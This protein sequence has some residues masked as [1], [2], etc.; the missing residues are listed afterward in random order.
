MNNMNFGYG[1]QFDVTLDH[2]RQVARLLP[3]KQEYIDKEDSP[4][5][6]NINGKEIQFDMENWTL[7]L[8]DV[9]EDSLLFAQPEDWLPKPVCDTACCL[10]G[11]AHLL[12]TGRHAYHGPHSKWSRQSAA[13]EKM[14]LIFL[15]LEPPWVIRAL[16]LALQDDGTFDL[17]SLDMTDEEEEVIL[18]AI[19][20]LE[21]ETDWDD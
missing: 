21:N 17:S 15:A 3:T 7:N 13:H 6:L 9:Y 11:S 2:V 8:I 16:V 4:V 14:S 20:G 19:W 1:E 5:I 10:F 12:A 18:D